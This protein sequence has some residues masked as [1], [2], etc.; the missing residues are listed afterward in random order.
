MGT[1]DHVGQ[2]HDM[3]WTP[4]GHRGEV[5]ASSAGCPVHVPGLRQSF[6][7]EPVKLEMFRHT[8]HQHVLDQA[9]ELM[10]P[11]TFETVN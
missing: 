2:W 5:N 8:T 1:E 7:Q 3:V 4:S 10:S 9:L 11:R 6:R